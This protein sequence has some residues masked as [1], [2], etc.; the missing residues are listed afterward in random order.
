MNHVINGIILDNKRILLVRKKGIWILPGGKIK[1]GE[2][3]LEALARE[4]K[5]ELSETEIDVRSASFYKEF[6]GLTPHTQTPASVRTYHL[7]TPLVIGEPS[8][9]IEAKSWMDSS[10][11]YNYPVSELTK[12]IILSLKRDLYV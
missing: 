4:F 12:S 2:N 1:E 5:E 3:E 9:E 6:H 8:A 10:E 11:A 7:R